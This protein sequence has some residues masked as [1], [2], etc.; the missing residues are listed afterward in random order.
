LFK[1]WYEA[2]W[3]E[4][5]A[6]ATS[7]DGIHWERPVVNTAHG[8]NRVADNIWPDSA[9]IF[10]DHFT[11]DPAQRYK[12]LVR[13]PGGWEGGFVMVSADGIHWSDPVRTGLMNDR[14]TTFYNPFLEKWVF[15]IRSLSYGRTRHYREH[16]DFI[17]GAAWTDDEPVFW[18]SADDL[19]PPDPEIGYPAQLYNL[20]AVAYEGIMIGLFEILL[21]PNNRDCAAQGRPKITEL[22]LAYSRDGFHWHR[23]DRRAFIASTRKS[24]DWD[25]GYLQSVGGVCTIVGDELRFYYSAAAGGNRD[26]DPEGGMYANRATGVARLRRD[27]FASMDAGAQEGTLL[28]RPL[29]FSGDQLW[30]NVACARGRLRAEVLDENGAA[31]EGLGLDDC[32]PVS[33]D[34]TKIQIAWR[35]GANLGVIAGR[36]VRIRFHL[37]NGSLYAFWVSSDPSGASNGYVAAGGPGYGGGIDKPKV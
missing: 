22:T 36:P 6:Y 21:G 12:M 33:V 10:L 34:A 28:T 11:D 29:V 35:D 26:T 14:S 30:V 13:S 8:D 5:L 31:V 3:C 24:G 2:A 18:A 27:G 25:Y 19:D 37:S 1:M 17:A 9:T 23:P 7:R 15:S 4:K 32:V 16:E 20:D